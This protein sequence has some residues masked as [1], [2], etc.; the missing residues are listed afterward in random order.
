M[1][2]NV[3]NS[4]NCLNSTETISALLEHLTKCRREIPNELY[5]INVKRISQILKCLKQIKINVSDKEN[6]VQ[7]NE[8]LF[9]S[10]T[11]MQHIVSNDL[12]IRI[13]YI[14]MQKNEA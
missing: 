10:A 12:F 5:D 4:E 8:E 2:C 9:K 1:D 3:I 6:N 11:E 7:I 13:N 14:P